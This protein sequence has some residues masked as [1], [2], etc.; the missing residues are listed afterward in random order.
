MGIVKKMSGRSRRTNRN[1]EL[2]SDEENSSDST[3]SMEEEQQRDLTNEEVEKMV[4][5]QDLTGIDDLQIC[6]ALL[7]SKQWDLEA[8]AKEH[9]NIPSNEPSISP[10]RP[11]AN[12][13]EAPNA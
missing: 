5:L 13:P 10:P 1:E 4:Q 2:S 9:L 12:I 11:S 7:E 3:A 8:V 6:R